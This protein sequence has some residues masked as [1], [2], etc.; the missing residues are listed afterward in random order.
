L[1]A[2]ANKLPILL[3]IPKGAG[4]G[5]GFYF[6]FVPSGYDESAYDGQQ[7]ADCRFVKFPEILGMVIL[8]V[9]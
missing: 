9:N 5:E 8:W 1:T 3:T 7:A 4:L 2:W 6:F